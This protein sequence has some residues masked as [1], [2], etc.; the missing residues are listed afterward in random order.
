MIAAVFCLLVFP[1]AL[2][3]AAS[4]SDLTIIDAARKTQSMQSLIHRLTDKRAVFIGED[5]DRYDNHLNQL[6]IIRE[7]NT[8]APGRWVIGVE[9]IQRRF[10][11]YLDAYINKTIS[12][13]EFLRQTDYFG[14]WGFDWRLY[15]PIFRYARDHNIP[16]VALNAE[17]ELTDE[18]D[19]SGLAALPAANRARLP[20][21][22]ED[23]D[24]AYRERLRK[25]FDA[26]PDQGN[27]DRFVEAQLVWDETMAET[28]ANYLAAHPDRAMI[29]LAGEGHIAFRSGIPERVSRRL[30][31][32]QV[33]VL[34]PADKPGDDLEG[35]DYLL[36]SP[37]LPLPQSG[38]MGVTLNTTSEVSVKSVSANS[39]AAASGLHAGDR[40]VEIDGEP[41]HSLTDFRLALL[42]KKPRKHVRLR[43]QRG[44]E[45]KTVQLTL[46]P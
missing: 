4:K 30:P 15:R 17:R 42:D 21:H 2:S 25:I 36:V 39:A 19:R 5:H 20:Q 37:M 34:L 8:H 27:F 24:A 10:Q 9:Y 7:L 12:E 45:E 32:I 6:Q 29:V 14:R 43:I 38:K 28:V 1:A 40:I 44:T 22:I 3:P 46:R 26:H 31:G 41:V 16:M 23:A 33:A 13:P 11:P 35:A 18:V